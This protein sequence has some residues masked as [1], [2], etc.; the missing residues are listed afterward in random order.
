[1]TPETAKT[2]IEA[3]RVDYPRVVDLARHLSLAVR[4]ESELLR[5]MR[6]RV[7]SSVE[8][9]VEADLYFSPL[10]QTRDVNAISLIPAVRELLHE[11]LAQHKDEL[12]AAREVIES[13]HKE[14]DAVILLEEM[15]AYHALR[16]DQ[17]A[18]NA[19]QRELGRVILELEKEE[20]DTDLVSWAL[21]AH[22][23]LPDRAR[24]SQAGRVL[25]GLLSSN[26]MR[27]GVSIGTQDMTTASGGYA[28]SPLSFGFRATPAGVA[29]CYPHRPDWTR[30]DTLGSEPLSLEVAWPVSGGWE[31]RMAELSGGEA[32]K[33]IPDVPLGLVRLRGINGDESKLRADGPFD[34]LKPKLLGLHRGLKT[35]LPG[36][37]ED[38]LS[39]LAWAQQW[40]PLRSQD[41]AVVFVSMPRERERMASLFE[42]LKRLLQS[43]GMSVWSADENLSAGDEWERELTLALSECQS[44]VVVLSPETSPESSWLFHELS[45]LAFRQESDPDF[46]LHVL[47]ADGLPPQAATSLLAGMDLPDL[48][49]D[50]V[51]HE[52]P[53]SVAK[54]IAEEVSVL[55]AKAD[56]FSAGIVHFSDSESLKAYVDAVSSGKAKFVRPL[57][58]LIKSG[59]PV[60]IY[61]GESYQGQT[62]Q[63]VL[64]MSE[65]VGEP[66]MENAMQ[67]TSRLGIEQRIEPL[68]QDGDDRH[69][70]LRRTLLDA[71]RAVV[72]AWLKHQ[73]DAAASQAPPSDEAVRLRWKISDDG[74]QGHRGTVRSIAISADGAIALTAG[75]SH[76]DQTVKQWDLGNRRLLRTYEGFADGG[77]W[78]PIAIAPDS[79]S[80]ITGYQGELRI[81]DLKSGEVNQLPLTEDPLRALAFIDAERYLVGTA[82]G[83]LLLVSPTGVEQDFTYSREEVV[84]LAVFDDRAVCLHPSTLQLIDLK[85]GASILNVEIASEET[86]LQWHRPPLH[87]DEASS[88]ILFGSPLQALD[89]H[90]GKV[91]F[92]GDLSRH[93]VEV[94]GSRKIFYEGGSDFF[95][96][97][98]ASALIVPAITIEPHQPSSLVLS[99]NGRRMVIADYEHN[100]YVYDLSPAVEASE[101]MHEEVAGSVPTENEDEG[102]ADEASLHLIEEAEKDAER[103]RK[104]GYSPRLLWVKEK[105]GKLRQL[106]DKHPNRL[107]GLLKEYAWP[108]PRL[109]ELLDKPT[110]N[111]QE[112]NAIGDLLAELGDPRPGVGLNDKGLPDIDWV[113]I[114]A[115]EFIYGEGEGEQTLHLDTYYMSRYPITNL[116]F[117]AF[118]DDGGY[119]QLQWWQGIKRMSAQKSD[120]TDVNRPKIRVGLYEAIAFCRW[121]SDR[122]GTYVRIP[123][124]QEWEKAARGPDGREYPWGN[125]YL[126]GA[127]NI[128]EKEADSGS[129]YLAHTCAVGLFPRESL[130]YGIQD[131]A[132]NIWEWCQNTYAGSGAY[133]SG[134]RGDEHVI[135]GGSWYSVPEDARCV[136]R[137]KY[138]PD[139]RNDH[140][141][142]RILYS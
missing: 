111:A 45:I 7:M 48:L 75:N 60:L 127:A 97:D 95:V 13:A 46:S 85:K 109:V 115:G 79:L 123:S 112:R 138:S 90:T 32:V 102:T 133:E 14:M 105:I 28:M 35:E 88:N 114:P 104:E 58:E 110:L 89:I 61:A 76:P 120:W 78:T 59:R 40:L 27:L 51:W 19:M 54:A 126:V 18:F 116:Q 86:G 108:G 34:G 30:V 122:T 118:I 140:I 74:K 49:K 87:V 37:I 33:Q 124:E 3:E 66:L 26:L 72:S 100:L 41:E 20:A 5:A 63:G 132:G 23:R 94:A 129:N 137:D 21:D 80:A 4:I 96:V 15:V 31:S 125:G 50:R 107:T 69:Q 73:A 9:G 142:F 36:F 25:S 64:K 113:E 128:N 106:I 71:E 2:L 12:E 53:E 10:V 83:R 135:R 39:D 55:N 121:L 11:E 6:L 1:M 56:D 8:A 17:D 29:L 141:G 44:A 91:S 68:A 77:G 82:N 16:D 136:S 119:E 57:E 67:Q 70:L 42:M 93:I 43:M 103:W 101:T 130:S 131:M 139:Y 117:Q 99:E 24:N 84:R 52:T 22:P 65:E 98:D 81:I 134:V 47:L 92:V 62:S 38:E